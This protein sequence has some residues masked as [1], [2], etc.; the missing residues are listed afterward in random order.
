MRVAILG[1]GEAGSVYA[2]E[3]LAAGCEVYG[4]D[5]REVVAPQGVHLAA[6]AAE[7]ATGASVVLSLTTAAGAEE[8]AGAVAGVLGRGTVYA[9]LNAG[10]PECKRAVAALLDGAL[11]ADVGVLA[12]VARAGLATPAL[13]SGPGARPL[14]SS[15][16]PWA[17]RS[18]W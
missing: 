5:R 9:D 11:M 3:F 7:A 8:A 15:S 2:R 4:Y 18:R 14:P 1:L 10:S 6:T 12:P 16:R 13:A 17:A